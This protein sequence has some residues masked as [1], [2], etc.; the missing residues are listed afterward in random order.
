MKTLKLTF[1]FLILFIFLSCDEEKKLPKQ[2]DKKVTVQPKEID[3]CSFLDKGEVE[4]IF[5][6]EMKDPKKGRSQKGDANTA[7]FSECSFESDTADT[8]IYLSVYLRFT[9]FKDEYHATIQNVRNSFKQSGI[10][11][12]N[13]E[14]IGEVA[15]WGGNQLHV[16]KGNNY[17]LIITLLGIKESSEA[18]E[19]A[20][21]VTLQAMRN[22]DS[23]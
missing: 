12:T 14:G 22:L 7:S 10:E 23:F 20:K 8:K 5:N 17:Y 3:A 15:F 21:A 9:P 18:I 11:V 16:F 13:I 2:D 4:K 6:I 1:F 19:K